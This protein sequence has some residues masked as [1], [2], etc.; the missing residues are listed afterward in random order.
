MFE[1]N[2]LFIKTFCFKS[3]FNIRFTP[4]GEENMSDGKISGVSHSHLIN[5]RFKVY[6]LLSKNWIS[7]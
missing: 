4:L 1:G 3:P 7:K 5:L 2:F 6:D